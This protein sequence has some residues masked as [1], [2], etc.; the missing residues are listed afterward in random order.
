MRFL[1]VA[2][3]CALSYAQTGEGSDECVDRADWTNGKGET[4]A[5][6]VQKVADVEKRCKRKYRRTCCAS[7]EEHD[8]ALRAA[9]EDGEGGSGRRAEREARREEREGET[10]S[11]RR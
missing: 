8:M 4:C 3:L 9:K 6:L 11:E 7:C 1:L 5:D 2:L 10:R